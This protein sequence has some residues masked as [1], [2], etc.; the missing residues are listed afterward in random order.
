MSPYT[1][2][3]HIIAH[4]EGVLVS[5]DEF[6]SRKGFVAVIEHRHD[7]RGLFRLDS[8]V[9]TETYFETSRGWLTA[10]QIICG[11]CII[12]TRKVPDDYP[13]LLSETLV[14][15]NF[16]HTAVR[17]ERRE[18]VAAQIAREARAALDVLKA[19]AEGHPVGRL[20]DGVE[21]LL[22]GEGGGSSGQA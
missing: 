5:L 11:D 18:I 7:P 9:E 20:P 1:P 21:A 22:K 6:G 8:D 17:V 15:S 19:L 3:R 4:L 2:L 12:A 14:A 16:Q 10:R 13:G